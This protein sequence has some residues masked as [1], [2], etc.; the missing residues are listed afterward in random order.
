MASALP[1]KHG[2]LIVCHEIPPVADSPM[3]DGGLRSCALG[4]RERPLMLFIVS[5]YWGAIPSSVNQPPRPAAAAQR[6]RP[7]TFALHLEEYTSIWRQRAFCPCV[8]D[9]LIRYHRLRELS[10]AEWGGGRGGHS[11]WRRKE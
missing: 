10:R 3:W 2:N 6:C 8:V 5:K 1:A 7:L 11:R 9:F 4:L